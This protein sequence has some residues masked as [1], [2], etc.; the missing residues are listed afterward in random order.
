MDSGTSRVSIRL[1][2]GVEQPQTVQAVPLVAGEPLPDEEIE[3]ILERLP[4][5]IEEPDDQV[6]FLLAQDP[7][8]PPLT[9]ETIEQPFPPPP[10]QLHQLP[11]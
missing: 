3:R 5:L 7:I 1:S 2:E 10:L 8:P 11:N 9:G 6:D 4:E